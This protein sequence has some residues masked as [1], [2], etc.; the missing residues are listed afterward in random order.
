MEEDG[1]EGGRKGGSLLFGIQEKPA[2]LPPWSVGRKKEERKEKTGEGG[3]VK[4]IKK[5]E[6]GATSR[7]HSRTKGAQDR[8]AKTDREGERGAGGVGG[9][10]MRNRRMTSEKYATAVVQNL[11]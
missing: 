9:G 11:R 2:R 8:R 7:H 6:N 5:K 1:R 4:R 3:E 10:L